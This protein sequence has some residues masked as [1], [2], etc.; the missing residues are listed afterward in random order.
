MDLVCSFICLI[1]RRLLDNM[2][3]VIQ[4][5]FEVSADSILDQEFSVFAELEFSLW[6]PR[7]EFMPHF[8]RMFEAIGTHR[9]LAE[10]LGNGEFYTYKHDV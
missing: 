9:T 5:R 6:V 10:Y 4:R 8:L 1:F 3:E 7:R 2:T